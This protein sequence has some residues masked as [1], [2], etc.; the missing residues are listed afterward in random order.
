[1][2]KELNSWIKINFALFFTLFKR[3]TEIPK[4]FGHFKE[5]VS[6]FDKK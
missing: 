2:Y 3:L 5:L 4:A 6:N 1:M